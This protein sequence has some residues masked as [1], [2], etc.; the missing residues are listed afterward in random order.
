MKEQPRTITRIATR[1]AGRNHPQMFV[2]QV[3]QI[4]V[5][6]QRVVLLQAV[7]TVEIHPHL[8]LLTIVPRQA[9]VAA[10]ILPLLRLLTIVLHQAEVAVG[11]LL[12]LRH[13][14]VVLRRVVAAVE[15]HLLRLPTVVLRQAGVAVRRR[16][17]EVAVL[18]R[19]VQVVQAVV[20]GQAVEVVRQEDSSQR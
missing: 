16:L 1:E 7:V 6:H 18:R 20:R 13:L 17:R 3:L 14:T 8:R 11:I 2:R 15:V 10:E 19:A 4:V 5:H 9:E 12:L